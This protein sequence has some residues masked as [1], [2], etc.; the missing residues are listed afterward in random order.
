[1]EW[2]HS[3]SSVLMG[4]KERGKRYVPMSTFRA[5]AIA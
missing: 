3:G 4:R 5:R 2:L 1:M